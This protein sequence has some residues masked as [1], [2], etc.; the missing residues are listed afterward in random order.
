MHMF[1]LDTEDLWS[2]LGVLAMPKVGV[3][4]TNLLKAINRVPCAPA[5]IPLSTLSFQ[6]FPATTIFQAPR[7]NEVLSLDIV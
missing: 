3:F 1:C 6:S 5:S 4:H 2:T 7:G